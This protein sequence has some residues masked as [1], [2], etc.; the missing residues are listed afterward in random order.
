MAIK[1]KLHCD[2]EIA[3]GDN[4]FLR[5]LLDQARGPG[6]HRSPGISTSLLQLTLLITQ[7]D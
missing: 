7:L 5:A 2:K 1:A 3:M 6:K 4:H